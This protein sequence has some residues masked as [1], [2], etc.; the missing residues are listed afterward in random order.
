M[1]CAQKQPDKSFMALQARVRGHAGIIC[2]AEQCADQLKCAWACILVPTLF[3]LRP[4]RAGIAI[5]TWLWHQLLPKPSVVW[6]PDHPSHH[7]TCR[8]RQTRAWTTAGAE[9]TTSRRISR[10]LAKYAATVLQCSL[11]CSLGTDIANINVRICS[12]CMPSIPPI[13]SSSSVLQIM[14]ERRSV[15]MRVNQVLQS[16]MAAQNAAQTA[17]L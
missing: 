17:A 10:P 2:S 16:K 13:L 15:M 6:L 8:K 9:S 3:G 11:V 1:L 7:L 14:H 4:S 12:C 5:A